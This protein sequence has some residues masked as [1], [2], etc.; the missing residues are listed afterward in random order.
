MGRIG[1]GAIIL[2]AGRGQRLGAVK[3]KPYL[4][5]NGKPTLCYSLEKFDRCKLIDEIVVVVNEDDL[6]L[7]QEEILDRYNFNK[8]IKVALGGEHRQDSAHAGVR[9]LEAEIILIHDGARPFFS[10]RLV[11]RLI[12]AAKEHGAAIPAIKLKDTIKSVHEDGF[13]AEELDRERLFAVQTPQCFTYSLIR[14]ALDEAAKRGLYFT[15]DAGA[16][17]YI[18]KVKPKMV[19]GE[20]ENIKITTPLDLKLAE[21]IAKD[22]F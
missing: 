17:S 6:R 15:D 4:E 22:L 16:V 7:F 20:E 21:L 12:E 13:A 8:E 11:E 19:E 2:A 5:I 9:A 14:Y 18:A 10:L 3:N 1:I